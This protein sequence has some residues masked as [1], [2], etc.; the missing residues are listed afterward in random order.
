MRTRP[1]RRETRWARG[2]DW[3]AAVNDVNM[4]PSFTSFDWLRV[5]SDS[6]D[7][8]QNDEVILPKTLVK[9]LLWCHG[10]A[11]IIPNGQVWN[12]WFGIIA[13]DGP[14]G[15]APPATGIPDVTNGALDWILWLPMS[16]RNATGGAINYTLQFLT[17]SQTGGLYSD[18]QRKLPP[19]KGLLWVLSYTGPVGST[20]SFTFTARMGLKGDVTAKGL[21]GG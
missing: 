7:P 17:S 13:W 14:D 20:F 18:A 19:S 6:A 12:A 16:A 9:T 5:P 1:P 3:D 10:G 2:F 4:A 11:N 15:N 21:G 8:L